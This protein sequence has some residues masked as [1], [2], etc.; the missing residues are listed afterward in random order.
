[1]DLRYQPSSFIPCP[2][3]NQKPYLHSNNS[4]TEEELSEI[5]AHVREALVLSRQHHASRSELTEPCI[6][7]CIVLGIVV[8]I[9]LLIVFTAPV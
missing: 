3:C 4:T 8:C 1:M 2:L 7:C 6:V 5:L 9:V